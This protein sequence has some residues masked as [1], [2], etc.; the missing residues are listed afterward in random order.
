M[1]KGDKAAN[2]RP[3][4]GGK[5]KRGKRGK[6]TG[7]GTKNVADYASLSET[8][9]LTVSGGYSTNRLYSLMNTSLENFSRA[10]IVAQGYQHY[11]IK[12]LQLRIKPTFDT[13]FTTND[14]ANVNT[15]HHV[16]YMIDKSGAIPTNITLE[17]LKNMGA[18]AFQL[19]EKTFKAGWRP[20]VME[21]V[22]TVAGAAPQAEGARYRIS[23]WLST[24]AVAV[25]NPFTPST[26]DHLGIYWYVEQLAGTAQ[27]YEV[28]IEA[29]FQFKKPLLSTAVG[30]FHAIPSS[31]AV[32]NAS[33]DGIVD[34]R[35]GGDD[36]ELAPS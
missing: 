17:G 9:T 15:K 12:Y 22:L 26:V 19:D 27:P 20:S 34:A 24:S 14:P 1:A 21:Q 7:R 8:H 35:P 16:Y 25:G 33:R 23:P 6:R 5:A 36:T 11:R 28:E 2:R 3:R 10:S 31:F 29:Q 30:A 32:A 4:R 18:K 13:F